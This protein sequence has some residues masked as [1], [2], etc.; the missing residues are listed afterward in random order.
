LR[1]SNQDS[2]QYCGTSDIDLALRKLSLLL[3]ESLADAPQY[4]EQKT[5]SAR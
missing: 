1:P 4:L 5:T 3:P 2:N